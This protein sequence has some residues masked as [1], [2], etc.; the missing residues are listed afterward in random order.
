MI[1]MPN[2]FLN[3]AASDAVAATAAATAGPHRPT[4]AAVPFDEYERDQRLRALYD[5]L[6]PPQPPL[7]LRRPEITDY[8]PD[9]SLAHIFK[10]FFRMDVRDGWL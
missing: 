7:F 3:P 4:A 6:D 1:E 9:P 2:P 8:R 10:V 5:E